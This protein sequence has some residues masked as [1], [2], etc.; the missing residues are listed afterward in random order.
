MRDYNQLYYT[1]PMQ[2]YSQQPYVSPLAHS[3]PTQAMPPSPEPE[4][5]TT[6]MRWSDFGRSALAGLAD[7]GA[8]IYDL[9]TLG[10]SDNNTLRNAANDLRE[11]SYA[12]QGYYE[13]NT[14]DIMGGTVASIAPYLISAPVSW[15][16]TAGDALHWASNN[17]NQPQVSPD[18]YMQ[19]YHNNGW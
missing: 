18:Q 14:L 19:T 8:G 15:A 13:P 5:S 4:M 7:V 3:Q 12:A 2:G 17:L 16:S 10:M 11:N 1:Q 6:A 9:A